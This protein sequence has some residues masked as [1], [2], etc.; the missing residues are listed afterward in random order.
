MIR[1]V[2]NV[3]VVADYTWNGYFYNKTQHYKAFS[4]YGVDGALLGTYPW[5]TPSRLYQTNSSDSYYA[6][7]AYAEYENTFAGKHFV[8]AFFANEFGAVRNDRF[9][10]FNPVYL[11]E[12]AI[13]GYPSWD[14]VPDNRFLNLDLTTLGGTYTGENRSASFIG[15]LAYV[16]DNRYVFNG[17]VRYDGVDI[18]GSDNQFAPLWSAGVKWNAHNKPFL[19]DYESVLSRLVLSVG[20]GYR[21]SINRSVLPFHTYALGTA[22]YANTPVASAFRYGNPVIKWE[23]KKETKPGRRDIFLQWQAEHGAALFQ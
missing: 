7:N 17:N 14:L 18:I 20:Y 23:K 6:L 8:Q 21:G 4:E 16:Y 3:R 1:P 11:Q 22:V 5:T 13:A 19:K 10:N 9:S 15:S 12:Y 2:K